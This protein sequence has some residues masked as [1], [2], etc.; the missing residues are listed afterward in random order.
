[1]I[2]LALFG[3]RGLFRPCIGLR[4]AVHVRE[5]PKALA[6]LLVA[7]LEM[8]ADGIVYEAS[9]ISMSGWAYTCNRRKICSNYLLASGPSNR[10]RCRRLRQLKIY[11]AEVSGKAVCCLRK[12]GQCDPTARIEFGKLLGKINKTARHM[13]AKKLAHRL[14]QNF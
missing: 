13:M 10:L 6:P 14:R 9:A 8:L 3:E 12:S 5:M 4:I 2:E 1:M 11:G 7:M